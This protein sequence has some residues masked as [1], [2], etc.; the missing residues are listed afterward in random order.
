MHRPGEWGFRWC[1]A[2]AAHIQALTG[3]G[4]KEIKSGD[5]LV[6]ERVDKFERPLQKYFARA[7]AVS[8]EKQARFLQQLARDTCRQGLFLR[9]VC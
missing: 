7:G 2:A 4:A 6:P 5:W 8:L 1:P 9:G 3:L